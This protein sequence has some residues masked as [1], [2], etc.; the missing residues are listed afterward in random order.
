MADWPNS[1]ASLNFTL[2]MGSKSDFTC[3]GCGYTTTVCG[4]RDCGM[5]AVLKTMAC[6]NCRELVDVLI[7]KCGEDGLTGDP[8]LDANI[9]QCP[10]C[11]GNQVST[12]TPSMPCPKCAGSMNDR[13]V[14]ILWD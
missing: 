5:L 14:R 11:K 2:P 10:I 9:G 4:G 3:S 13:G 6:D 1:A 7:G 12:W 8:E